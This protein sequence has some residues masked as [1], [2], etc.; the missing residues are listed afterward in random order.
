VVDNAEP[1]L[2]VQA[3]KGTLDQ[4]PADNVEPDLIVPVVVD[5]AE[6]DLIVQEIN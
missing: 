5:N 4:V 2:I 3:A 6:P 1:D